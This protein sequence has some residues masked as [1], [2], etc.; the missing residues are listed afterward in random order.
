MSYFKTISIIVI[1]ACL[2][3]TFSSGQTSI[4]FSDP[5]DISNLL[6]YRLPDWSYR[7]WD[8][9]FSLYGS[10]DDIQHS[11]ETTVGN[12]FFSNFGSR[13]NQNWE[14]EKR[15]IDLGIELNGDYSRHHSESEQEENKSHSFSGEYQ[16]SGSV[17]HFLTKQP[18][19]AQL[20]G[21]SNRSYQEYELDQRHIDEWIGRNSYLRS[22]FHSF[23]AGLG[24]GQMRN[25]VPLLRAQRL[26]E[27]L[28]TMG[29]AALSAQQVQEIAQ[30][31]ATEYAYREVFERFDRHFWS[32][33]LAPMLDENN[34]LTPFEIFYLTDI[35]NE[36]IG[37]RLQ[38]F[39]VGAGYSYYQR[40]HFDNGVDER[41]YNRA[42]SVQAQWYR[43]LSLTK[44]IHFTC[45]YQYKWRDGTD[46]DEDEARLILST[47]YLWNFTDRYRLNN[48]FTYITGS[49]IQ[50]DSR[51]QNFLLSSTFI[52]FL[53]DKVSIN[54]G[55][56]L[57][58][59]NERQ[60]GYENNL[61][62]WTYRIG[63]QYHLDRA[64]F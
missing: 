20:S 51:H 13:F 19:F 17:K 44:Q 63:L 7:T 28:T 22:S 39:S 36:D 2:A 32:D 55:I 21:S 5:A 8:V 53:E 12:R 59:S 37:D 34:P 25:V 64:I 48:T 52:I 6:D 31:L 35:I 26:S 33:V 54:S 27:R 38:G 42:P 9:D 58:Y 43:N 56:R 61:W 57:S 45:R 18:F 4:G 23:Y 14:S 30:V 15:L 29:R 62:K 3:P 50:A 10:R 46:N 24:Y 16:F 11:G 47:G 41:S 60:A 40:S 1:L 49:H